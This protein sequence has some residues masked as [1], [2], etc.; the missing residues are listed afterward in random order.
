MHDGVDVWRKEMVWSFQMGAPTLSTRRCLLFVVR[1]IEQILVNIRGRILA[2]LTG[3]GS[4]SEFAV[5][6]SK[7]SIVSF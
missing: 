2:F 5:T 4:H 7:Q 3:S 6:R 1:S